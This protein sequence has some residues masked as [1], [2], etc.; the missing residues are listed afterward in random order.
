M[1]ETMPL[2]QPINIPRK[3]S[4][5]VTVLLVLSGVV[6]LTQLFFYTVFMVEISQLVELERL[7]I[8]ILLPVSIIIGLALALVSL[9]LAAIGKGVGRKAF[10]TGTGKARSILLLL[11]II[12]PPVIWILSHIGMIVMINLLP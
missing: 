7:A 6:F 5:A 9:T 12:L 3:P 2:S 10:K 1:N 8:I 11:L 4:K